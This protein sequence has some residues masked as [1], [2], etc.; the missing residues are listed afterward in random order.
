MPSS[1][2]PA[3]T[4]GPAVN[5]AVRTARFSRNELFV[6]L[7]VIGFANGISERVAKVLTEA[8]LGTA[9]AGTFD[10][11]VVVWCAWALCIL[12]LLR[13]PIH[14]ASR[15]DE[16][17]VG[18]AGVAVLIPIAPLSWLALTGL[19]IHILRTSPPRS[20]SHRAGWILLALTVPM[21]W[22]RLL[23]AAFSDIILEADGILVGSLMGTPRIGNAIQLV[24][25]SGYLWIAP[26]CSSLANISIGILCWVTVT[27]AVNHQGSVRDT[28]WIALTLLAVIAIN[29]TRI[30]L[31]GFYPTH[32]DLIHGPVGASVASWLILGAALAICLMAVRHSG[33]AEVASKTALKLRPRL[34]AGILLLLASS[35]FFKMPG[36]AASP[37]PVEPSAVFPNEVANLLRARGFQVSQ[38]APEKDM[39]WVIGKM[40]NCEIRVTEA[41]PQGWQEGL[42]RSLAR[43]DQL[44]FVFA[45]ALYNDQPTFRT[46]A[47]FYLIRL[48]DYLGRSSAICPILAVVSTRA[49]KDIPLRELANLSRR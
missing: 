46:R 2:T 13:S 38:E 25:G 17:V 21:F 16:V 41:A 44:V 20:L 42:L 19:A 43:N 14:T 36:R 4:R 9:L 29:V 30:S 27:K 24:D 5:R 48:N 12:F 15:S 28:G 35:L 45:G 40:M 32:F 37:R 49:C 3:S 39:P 23:F 10:I 34:A 22:A 18:L 31:I 47:E 6:A 7:I 26:A 8:G 11:S 33:A 1:L